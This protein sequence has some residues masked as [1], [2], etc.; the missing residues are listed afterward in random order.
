MKRSCE[1]ATFLTTVPGCFFRFAFD[2]FV[3]NPKDNYD[4]E[5]QKRKDD[6]EEEEQEEQEEGEEKEDQ[7]ERV[8]VREKGEG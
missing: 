8:R 5:E 6:D 1:Y 3:F 7:E 2:V 4:E